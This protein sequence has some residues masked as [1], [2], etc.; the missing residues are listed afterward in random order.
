[1]HQVNEK[2]MPLSNKMEYESIEDN[3]AYVK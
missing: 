2:L 1:M 3:M